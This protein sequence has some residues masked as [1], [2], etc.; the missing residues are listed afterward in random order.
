MTYA[1]RHHLDYGNSMQIHS[2]TFIQVMQHDVNN[3]P[4]NISKPLQRALRRWKRITLDAVAL[5]F[6]FSQCHQ[7]NCRQFPL[8]FTCECGK[9]RKISSP[10]ITHLKEFL[11]EKSYQYW[12]FVRDVHNVLFS[13]VLNLKM[14]LKLGE[15]CPFW[16]LIEDI[17][18]ALWILKCKEKSL[19]DKL[20]VKKS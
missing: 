6:F 11:W 12:V 2:T 17:F 3:F 18:E 5:L 7:H 9:G 15:K 1:L 14:K 13:V 19:S 10:L 4:K 16:S 20:S 8:V